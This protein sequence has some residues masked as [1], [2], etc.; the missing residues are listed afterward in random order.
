VTGW[1]YTSFMIK[2]DDGMPYLN[3]AIQRSSEEY[4]T[5]ERQTTEVN[6]DCR[7]ACGSCGETWNFSRK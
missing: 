3:K 6:P 5:T 7:A 2:V 4:R 1:Y